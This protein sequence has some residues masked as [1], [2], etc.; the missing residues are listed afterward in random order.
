MGVKFCSLSSGSSGNCQFIG[1]DR[2]KILVDGGL[3]GIQIERLLA[4][5]DTCPRTI[6]YILVTHEHLDHVRGIGVLSR[7]FDIPILA[8]EKT[9][10]GMSK[11]I[12]K[13]KDENIRLIESNRSFK[14]GDLEINPFKIYHDALDPLGYSIYHKDAKISII[15]DTGWVCDN[16]KD[17]IKDSSLYFI[18]SN[19]DVKM[20]RE[21]S[22]PYYL[23]RRVASRI[24]HLSNM[25]TGLALSDILTGKGEKVILAHL[26]GENNCPD[27]AYKTVEKCIRDYSVDIIENI[28]IGLT[29]RD[30]PTKI[31]NL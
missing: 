15:T 13:I 19:H 4:S 30:R 6:D 21:G 31:Y 24:G 22:Y 26:S 9:W 1:T 23:K 5:I 3:S 25:E 27:L 28:E 8:N 2:T 14:L 29:Y 11:T 12:G 18:E 16:M 7:R 10:A 17:K 20:L